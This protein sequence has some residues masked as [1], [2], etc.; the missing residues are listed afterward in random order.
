[1][2][3]RRRT[4]LD[5]L[6][7][8]FAPPASRP[9]A[10][11][12]SGR[13]PG[14]LGGYILAGKEPV[15]RRD[16]D[17]VVAGGGIAGTCAAIAAART[18]VKAALVHERSMLGGNSSSEVRLYP[19]VST[20]H[21]VWSKEMGIVEE[22]HTEGRKFNHEPYLEGLMNSQ[23]D[24]VLYGRCLREPNLTLFLNTTVRPSRAGVRP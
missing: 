20:N 1:M 18:G 17:V 5:S 21:N 7:A 23:W 13:R 24:L 19:E 8:W 11:S 22:F 6:A 3:L 16:F 4:V 10:G 2:K 12:S 9:R 14:A 15:E